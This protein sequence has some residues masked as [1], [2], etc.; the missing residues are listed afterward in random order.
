MVR[1][2]GGK[3]MRNHRL[4][5]SIPDRNISLD[6]PLPDTYHT[7]VPATG[8]TSHVQEIHVGNRVNRGADSHDE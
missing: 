5:R 6:N 8:L 1:I 2:V 4:G 3:H 7:T